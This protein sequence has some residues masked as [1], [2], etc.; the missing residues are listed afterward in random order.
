MVILIDIYLISRDYN[1][2]LNLP[3]S[4]GLWYIVTKLY[5]HKC[6][7]TYSYRVVSSKRVDNLDYGAIT[8]VSKKLKV[9]STSHSSSSSSS[10]SS[11][12]DNQ[13]SQKVSK[14]LESTS[15]K[16]SK[17]MLYVLYMENFG[18]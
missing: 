1:E 2:L 18:G 13:I 6:H 12:D 11:D 4:V 10:S 14:T 17:S 3:C 15:K 9:T 7:N 8:T 16:L 5:V